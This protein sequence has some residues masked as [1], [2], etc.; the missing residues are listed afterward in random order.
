[1]SMPYPLAPS[2]VPDATSARS[3]GLRHVHLGNTGHGPSLRHMHGRA[4]SGEWSQAQISGVTQLLLV[5]WSAGLEAYRARDVLQGHCERH[6]SAAS[7]CA[8]SVWRWLANGEP[9]ACGQSR[10]RAAAKGRYGSVLMCRLESRCHGPCPSD[11]HCRSP[12]W[13][14]PLPD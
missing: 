13:L 5:V 2:Q 7:P 12:C 4:H 9:S 6:S 11:E 10:D 1:M 14:Q 8:E 3:L